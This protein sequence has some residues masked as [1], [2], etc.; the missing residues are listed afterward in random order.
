MFIQLDHAGEYICVAK[1]YS[2]ST[3]GAQTSVSLVVH[4]SKYIS[5]KSHSINIAFLMKYLLTLYSKTALK[6]GPSLSSYNQTKDCASE[7]FRT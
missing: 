7:R 5:Y 4:R 6:S 2:S 1:G 3:R